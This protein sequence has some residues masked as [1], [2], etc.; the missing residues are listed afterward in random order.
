MTSASPEAA[1]SELST[2]GMWTA[3]RDALSGYVARRVSVTEDVE[4][5]LQDIFIRIHTGAA[6]IREAD[7]VKS[8]VFGL[9][10]RAIADHYR[11][12]YRKPSQSSIDQEDEDRLGVVESEISLEEY[13]GEHGVHEEVLSWLEPMIKRLPETYGSALRLSDIEGKSQAQVAE[14]LGISYTAAKSRVQRARKL[15][16]KVLTDCCDVEFGSQG[17]VVEYRERNKRC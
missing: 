11:A 1:G 8:W 5:I 13:E 3:F 14:E 4:D 15:L 17:D 10:R 12:T 9:A 7:K 16:G 6:A 2:T